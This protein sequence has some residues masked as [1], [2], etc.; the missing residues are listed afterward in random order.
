MPGGVGQSRASNVRNGW[1]ADI[2]AFSFV[3]Q[4]PLHLNPGSRRMIRTLVFAVAL[5]ASTPA[6]ACECDD[7]ASLSDADSE[8]RSKWIANSGASIAE[9][10]LVRTGRGE[11][12]RTL[13]HLFGEPHASYPVRD[14]NGP[15]TSCDFGIAPGKRAVMAFLPQRSPRTR[16]ATKPCGQDASEAHRGFS[17]G[18]M[19]IQF[20]V[21]APGNLDRVRRSAAR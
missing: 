16:A 18:G 15:F 14:P 7:P 12:Y 19:C 5:A 1:K 17:P 21:Q 13:R 10:E 11:Q 2:A 3:V 4:F 8:E 6:L 9:V 20:Y